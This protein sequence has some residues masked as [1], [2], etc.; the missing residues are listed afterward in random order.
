M[1]VSDRTDVALKDELV[2]VARKA[3]AVILEIY[4]R[5]FSAGEKADRSPVTE[6]DTAAEAVILEAL[7]KLAPDLPVIAEE[8]AA[9][10][11]LPAD[12]A[13]RFFLVDPL[14]GTK[15]FIAKNGEFTVNI[16][17]IERGRPTLGVV[18]LP[19]TD[20][21]YAAVGGRA[22]RRLGTAAPQP[23]AARTSPGS[24]LVMAISRSHADGEIERAKA[25]G[26][27]VAGTIVA[28]SSLKFCRLA[29]GVADLYPRFGTTMEWDT[30]AG[31]AVLE[32]A[33]G[34]VET[35][36]GLPLGY[37]KAGF[38]NPHFIAYGRKPAAA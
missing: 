25:L 26:L 22:E 3:G 17:L 10:G 18:Y 9:S 34:R 38:K 35:V 19:A 12:A 1:Q 23:I 7:A 28:G 21:C 27:N 4:R 24:G 37:G 8:Q 14:D 6:A 15:E 20:A 2:A 13:A 11:G 32:A 30:A 36:E 5:D 16:A 29:E 33:G 31:Q